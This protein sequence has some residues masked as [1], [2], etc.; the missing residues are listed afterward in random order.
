M[1][2][3]PP[4]GRSSCTPRSGTSS[5]AP[6][7]GSATTA[8][9]RSTC[10]EEIDVPGVDTKFVE[11]PQGDPRRS[12]RPRPPRG[13]RRRRCP[14]DA[15]RASRY[16]FQPPSP[17]YVRPAL[18]RPASP[19]PFSELTVRA[20]E[21]A[22]PRLGVRAVSRYLE[23]AP[24]SPISRCRRSPTPSPSSAPGYA[25]ALLR[26][27]P[28]LDD[29]DLYYW[30]DIDTHGFAILDQVR[31]RFPHTTSLLYGPRHPSS[32]TSPTGARKSTQ[33]HGDLTHL[34]PEEAHLDH[35]LRTGTYHPHLRLEQ[36][37][38]AI[39]AVRK[40]LTRHRE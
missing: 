19:L 1:D 16:G 3:R 23:K 39:T 40:A 26:H 37:R 10:A 36:E 21:L 34:T 30:G 24:R 15:T 31:G 9:N 5:C 8:P 6:S 20:K 17:C 32:P 12:P 13:P 25:A 4:H 38:I 11:H 14:E 29:V 7:A 27:L 18:P 33:A 22:D 2:G 28:W 35:D